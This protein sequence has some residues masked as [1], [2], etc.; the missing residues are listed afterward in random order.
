MNSWDDRTQD[1]YHRRVVDGYHHTRIQ[2]DLRA[3]RRAVVLS[4]LLTA[5]FLLALLAA[6]KAGGGVTRP[7]PEVTMDPISVG[8]PAALER[9]WCLDAGSQ[10][11]FSCASMPTC[12]CRGVGR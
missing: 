8:A 9:V 2:R 11:R 10:V 3:E 1:Q 12:E 4:V 6:F 7:D 5:L